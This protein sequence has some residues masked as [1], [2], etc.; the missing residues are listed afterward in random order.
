M[1][2]DIAASQNP[3]SHRMS[4]S[5]PRGHTPCCPAKVRSQRSWCLSSPP[6]PPLNSPVP[7]GTAAE[8]ST[9]TK[10]PRFCVFAMAR[11]CRAPQPVWA[12]QCHREVGET[13]LFLFAPGGQR[14]WYLCGLEEFLWLCFHWRYLSPLQPPAVYLDRMGYPKK[15]TNHCCGGMAVEWMMTSSVWASLSAKSCLKSVETGQAWFDSPGVPKAWAVTK[16]I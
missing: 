15:I 3:M 5:L 16:I 8:L 2:R 9:N 4:L 1:R 12:W 11:S 10:A 7:L 14:L 6:V 13:R